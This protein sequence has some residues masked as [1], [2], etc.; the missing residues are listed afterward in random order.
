MWVQSAE[1]LKGILQRLNRTNNNVEITIHVVILS[2]AKR[3]GGD[4]R[5]RKATIYVNGLTYRGP[6]N[7]KIR[8]RRVLQNHPRMMQRIILWPTNGKR[9]IYS[10]LCAVGA[11]GRTVGDAPTYHVFP[12]TNQLIAGYAHYIAVTYGYAAGSLPSHQ[13]DPIMRR[14]RFSVR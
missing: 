7:S 11:C 6:V 9:L 10:G 2:L 14:H 4:I 5:A 12:Y 8:T 3:C 1:C 13:P